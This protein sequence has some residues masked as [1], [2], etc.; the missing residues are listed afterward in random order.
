[1]LKP[2]TKFKR[3][4]D[5]FKI[6]LTVVLVKFRDKK[7]KN[8]KYTIFRHDFEVQV[9]DIAVVDNFISNLNFRFEFSIK[10]DS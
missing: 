8:P 5:N 4:Q 6:I 9:S 2:E 1:M 3:V 7:R 10:V